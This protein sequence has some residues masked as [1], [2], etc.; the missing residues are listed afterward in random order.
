MGTAYKVKKRRYNQ[1]KR[2]EGGEGAGREGGGGYLYCQRKECAEGGPILVLS[3]KVNSSTGKEKPID[4]V[5][6]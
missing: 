6:D 2:R 4:G 1:K 5:E 3:S